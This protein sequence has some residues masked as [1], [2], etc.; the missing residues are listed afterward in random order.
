MPRLKGRW[1]AGWNRQGLPSNSDSESGPYVHY[2]D[3]RHW[4][5]VTLGGWLPDMP[6]QKKRA[7]LRRI[8]VAVRG[9]RATDGDFF[10][11]EPQMDLEFF[12]RRVE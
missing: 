9:H 7:N 12:I 4:L 1:I 10:I 2:K 3:A 11:A 5:D 6:D 8:R